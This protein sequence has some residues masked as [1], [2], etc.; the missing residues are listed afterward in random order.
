P[1]PPRVSRTADPREQPEEAHSFP[2]RR[3]S[4]LGPAFQGLRAAWRHGDDAF[5][6][7]GRAPVC[8]PVAGAQG[9][10]RELVDAG[11]RGAGG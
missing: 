8:T 4:D 10:L 5:A 1:P 2:T 6:E 7:I 3:S 11:V 9:V